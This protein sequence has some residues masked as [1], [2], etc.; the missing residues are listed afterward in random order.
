MDNL[1]LD[2][3]NEEITQSET[4]RG[5]K[6]GSGGNTPKSH[7]LSRIPNSVSILAASIAL[8]GSGTMYYQYSNGLSQNRQSTNY[9]ADLR[10][11][12]ERIEKVTLLVRAADIN[13]FSVLEDS[14]N[15]IDKITEVLL[16][17][18]RLS[19]QDTVIAPISGESKRLLDKVVSDF[20]DVKPLIANVLADK[21]K[22]AQFKDDV[23]KVDT[24][25]KVLGQEVVALQKKVNNGNTQEIVYLSNRIS[26]GINNLFSSSSFTLDKGY[27]VVKDLRQIDAMVSMLQ[28]GSEVYGVEAIQDPKT[29]EILT[30]VKAI[31]AKLN[32]L[33]EKTVG[34][35]GTVNNS[36]DAALQ[37]TMISK[38]LVDSAQKINESLT[39][40]L[41]DLEKNKL[42]SG[43]LLII[44]GLFGILL[45][46]SLNSRNKE[47]ES[48]RKYLL[49]KQKNDNA[50]N[51]LIEQ[52]SHIENGDF[53]RAIGVKDEF[54]GKVAK[55]MNSIR[56]TFSNIVGKIKNT[57]EIVVINTEKT[58]ETA[59]QLLLVSEIQSDKIV[60]SIEK[61]GNITNDM[62]TAAQN[63]W[64]AKEESEKSKTAS[65]DGSKLVKET[66]KKMDEI[67]YTIQ[68]SSKKIKKL[69]E[70]AQSITEV[71]GIIQGITKQINILAL[72]AAIQAASSGESGREFTI[73]AQEVQR[74]A[75]DSKEAT[76]KI[77]L[78]IADIQSDTAVAI[79][80]MEKTT[81]EVVQGAKLTD[82]VGVA[83]REI[84]Q[85]AQLVAEQ[86]T[87]SA[88]IMEEKSIEMA[89]VALEIQKVKDKSMENLE[90]A[91]DV[92]NQNDNLK[93]IT[94]DLKNSISQYKVES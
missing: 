15:K 50:I 61:I 90:I 31:T 80:S 29:V 20:N 27:A 71:T 87:T 21:G 82:S 54:I 93:H 84:E 75:D 41:N 43:I 74:L 72:N 79:A 34:V 45:T 22:I 9:V 68:E 64:I 92:T 63:I 36:K 58:D 33:A 39:N 89:K 46:A 8:I 86:V 53:T 91:R 70:S 69:G 44:A 28:T 94:A 18:G 78:L 42:I 35:V 24:E 81:Q 66:I 23:T 83:L 38:S 49:K 3:D 13:A 76:N 56:I 25:L 10:Q 51:E 55:Q 6:G 60:E 30:R 48:A 1:S 26:N 77:E 67:R 40:D 12:A 47:L 17:G 7:F 65:K 59:N 52:M 4:T 88:N 62:D 57:S 2:N 5:S 16:K 73:V 14:K 32:E 19:E 37:I 85:L 11:Y